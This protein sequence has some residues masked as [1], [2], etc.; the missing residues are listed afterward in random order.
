MLSRQKRITLRKIY[1]VLFIKELNPE[2]KIKHEMND[3]LK[4]LC[5]YSSLYHSYAIALGLFSRLI[6]LA[7]FLIFNC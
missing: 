3:A 4:F 2:I 6:N 7:Y 1:E 5:I